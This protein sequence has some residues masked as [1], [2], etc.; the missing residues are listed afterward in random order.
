MN[1]DK[2]VLF[3]GDTETLSYFSRR[4]AEYFTSVGKQVFL[5][6]FEE[7]LE[8]YL[9]LTWFLTP[10][11]VMVTF[12]FIGFC[13]EEIFIEENGRSV[14]DNREILCLNIVVD[15]PFYYHKF[16]PL[17][18]KRYVQFSIDRDH[19]AYLK[20]FFPH[21]TSGGFL[22]L[23]GTE[24]NQNMDFL[25][26]EKDML[27]VAQSKRA[28]SAQSRIPVITACGKVFL[29]DF[30]GERIPYQ[31]RSMD[32]VFTGNY[33]PTD[34]LRPYLDGFSK[35]YADFYFRIIDDFLENPQMGMDQGIEKHLWEEVEDISEEGI[36]ACM[37]NT[38][39]IDLFV[40][41]TFRAAAVRTLADA[42]FR[43]HVF[44]GGWEKFPCKHPENIIAGGLLD[45]PGCLKMLADSRISLNV[46]PWFKQGAHDRVFNSMLCGA[47]SLTDSSIY[48]K[49]IIKDGQQAVFYELNDWD[50]LSERVEY[51]LSHTSEAEE[52]AVSGYQFAAAHHRWANRGEAIDH[53]LQNI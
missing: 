3:T 19:E 52:I 5:F 46:M 17:L 36:K 12:N 6:D 8:S 22:P 34:K 1:Y 47:V 40:R 53:Y 51:L 25:A 42:G 16:E 29:N 48:L 50:G 26:N 21:I 45:S 10:R 28:A 31:K 33:T 35:E 38:I 32:I 27:T 44:G 49:E 20:R 11:T 43:V 37:P 2:V 30:G 4:L 15:H 24:Y 18:P 14:W 9:K 13:G 23:A 41:F 39:F 7:E